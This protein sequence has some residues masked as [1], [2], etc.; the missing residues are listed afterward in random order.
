MMSKV[1]QTF[2]VVVSGIADWGMYVEEP[3]A[4][5]EGLIRL[6]DLKPDDYYTVDQ[7]NYKIIGQN[8]KKE[9]NIG[10][11]VKVKLVNADLDSKMLDYLIVG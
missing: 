1:G 7:K 4:K 5:A 2:D 10:D 9:F 6:K 11:P 8:T 3:E